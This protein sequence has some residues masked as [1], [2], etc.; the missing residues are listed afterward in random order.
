MTYYSMKTY[1]LIGFD[2]SHRRGKQ[3]DGILIR[4]KDKKIIRVPFGDS[5]MNNYQDKTGLNA[6][7]HLIHGDKE[8]RRLFRARMK[9]FLK[10]GF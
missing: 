10:K 4:L 3:Y 2:I 5:T 6:Y 8:R 1:K 7:P 9:G